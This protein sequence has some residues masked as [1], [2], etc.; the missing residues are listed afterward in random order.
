MESAPHSDI[1][2]LF[3]VRAAATSRRILIAVSILLF[4]LVCPSVFALARSR[5]RS[6]TAKLDT[7]L[8]TVAQR[9]DQWHS[10]GNFIAA[11]E[12]DAQASRG[13]YANKW[14]LWVGDPGSGGRTA[15]G[16]KSTPPEWYKPLDWW[17]EEHGLI[18][19]NPVPLPAGQYKVYGDITEGGSKLLTIG[20]NGSWRLQPGVAID[21]VTHHPCKAFRYMGGQNSGCAADNEA[22]CE[23]NGSPVE[24][25]VLIV[26]SQTIT[27]VP[28]GDLP[29]P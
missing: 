16:L 20:P 17:K 1:E 11:F 15:T 9:N 18:M 2:P 12:R 8:S 29:L 5:Q 14:G 23:K 27:T 24:Y 26:D 4:V 28:G 7:L 13:S 25:K 10:V 22:A 3:A 21:Q 6:E 19:P